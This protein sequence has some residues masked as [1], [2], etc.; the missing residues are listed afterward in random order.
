MN[1]GRILLLRQQTAAAAAAAATHSMT[2]VGR[3]TSTNAT[4]VMRITA[5]AIGRRFLGAQAKPS[6]N[7]SSSIAVA[8]VTDAATAC[9]YENLVQE[10]MKR[11]IRNK[12]AAA[13]GEDIKSISPEEIEVRFNYY[14]KVFEE[15]ELCLSDLRE[16]LFEADDEQYRE[17]SN[18]AEGAV[19][20]AFTA[21]VDLLEDLRRSSDEQLHA[22]NEIRNT[23]A[24]NLKRLR[25]ELD[26]IIE[27]AENRNLA[28][29]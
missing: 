19:D 12:D 26:S 21:Y 5:S 27:V 8:Q 23:N 3:Q 18:C 15:A 11:M 10:T 20:N 7:N 6:V 24:C 28:A 1:V 17:E 13:Q 9:R 4:T 16:T 29:S 25:K 2:M 22:Y 14:K